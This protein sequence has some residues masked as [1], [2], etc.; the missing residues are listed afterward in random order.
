MLVLVYVLV[1]VRTDCGVQAVSAIRGQAAYI[2]GHIVKLRSTLCDGEEEGE[3]GIG[4][5]K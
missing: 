1:S 5:I 4:H 3:N 2:G